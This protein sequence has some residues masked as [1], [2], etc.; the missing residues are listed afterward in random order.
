MARVRYCASCGGRLPRGA[1]SR[2]RYCDDA[3][4]AQAY[5]DRK[6]EQRRL[7]FLTLLG[8]AHYASHRRLIRALTCPVC[9][10]ATMARASRRR[11]AV[12]CSGRC[13]SRAWRQRASRRA[14]SAA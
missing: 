3:C 14:R 9:G 4:R 11:D 7:D 6:A 1:S 10:R 2:R 13:R 12:Y 8:Q 5:R